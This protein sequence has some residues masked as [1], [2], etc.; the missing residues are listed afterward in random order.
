MLGGASPNG[1]RPARLPAV[2]PLR[3]T[4]CG[5]CVAACPPHALSLAPRGWVKVA[6]L[7]A[8]DDC[9]PCG[10]C[11]RACPFDAVRMAATPAPQ[12]GRHGAGA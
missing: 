10:R 6:E 1:G 4:G 12:A 7:H 8:P 11:V 5:R 9:S 3:C 2:D